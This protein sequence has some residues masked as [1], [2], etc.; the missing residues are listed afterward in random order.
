MKITKRQLKRIIKE[1]KAKLQEMNAGYAKVRRGGYQHEEPDNS[2]VKPTPGG[3]GDH[4]MTKEKAHTKLV[5]TILDLEKILGKAGVEE[6][7]SEL[8][9]YVP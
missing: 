7:L 6:A 9:Y 1:E 4:S 8:G 3:Y 2:E 5:E